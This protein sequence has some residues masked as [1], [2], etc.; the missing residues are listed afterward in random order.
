MPAGDCRASPPGRRCHLEGGVT[1]KGPQPPRAAAAAAHERTRAAT[2]GRAPKSA[3][4]GRAASWPVAMP[5]RVTILALALMGA[6][7]AAC[8]G[9]E[10]QKWDCVFLHGAGELLVRARIFFFSTTSQGHVWRVRASVCSQANAPPERSDAPTLTAAGL[11]CGGRTRCARC[12]TSLAR[13]VFPAEAATDRPPFNRAAPR[14]TGC[15]R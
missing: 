7:V 3:P 8:A 9:D 10:H 5:P 15:A 13:L 1:L 11:R 6:A 4:R 12:W 14:R 2:R